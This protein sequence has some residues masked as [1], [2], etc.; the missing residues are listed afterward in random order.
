[1][2]PK[3]ASAPVTPMSASAPG[4]APA[5]LD[6]STEWMG[7]M[8]R[9]ASTLSSFV[10]GDNIVPFINFWGD[11]LQSMTTEMDFYFKV[12]HD[13]SHQ[14]WM[15]S[16]LQTD[17]I[18]PAL[19]FFSGCGSTE[20][21]IEMLHSVG[22]AMKPRHMGSWISFTEYGAI[23]GGW[24]FPVK[25]NVKDAIMTACTQPNN[26]TPNIYHSLITWVDTFNITQCMM[27]SRDMGP[28]PPQETQLVIPLVLPKDTP[29]TIDTYAFQ[30]ITSAFA[31]FDFPLP[32]DGLETLKW[33]FTQKQQ[34]QQRSPVNLRISVA[35]EHVS[36]L[37]VSFLIRY[38]NAQDLSNEL[39]TLGD[40]L[41]LPQ[42]RYNELPDLRELGY[43]RN[44]IELTVSHLK[45][46]F[47]YG[48]YNP[49]W[50]L[51]WAWSTKFS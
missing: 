34:I 6:V 17:I 42:F 8:G 39:Q 48:V 3:P 19:D 15:V 33:V 50:N 26:P 46:D 10:N 44:F 9:V 7:A 30:I 14:I 37:E 40:S 35:G 51:F 36:K 24:T 20:Q 13:F 22:A 27:L 11:N 32:N 47:S 25:S 41:G 28:N 1:M 4:P 16:G 43:Q 12:S 29:V 23:E 38:T 49:G 5:S 31:A 21:N 45:S 18:A 2:R